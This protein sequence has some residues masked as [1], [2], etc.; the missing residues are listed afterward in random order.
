MLLNE[1]NVY[2]VGVTR[3]KK[4]D[5]PN[6]EQQYETMSLSERSSRFPT[7]HMRLN[8]ETGALLPF[9]GIEVKINN[10][11][12]SLIPIQRKC[13]DPHAFIRVKNVFFQNG[14]QPPPIF[15]LAISND[16]A[17]QPLACRTFCSSPNVS[18]FSIGRPLRSLETMAA[19][20]CTTPLRHRSFDPVD[21]LIA[22]VANFII[23][24]FSCL[25]A[26]RETMH[27]ELHKEENEVTHNSYHVRKS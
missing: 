3:R 27:F 26:A 13:Q 24:T 8:G 14:S 12:S 6:S 11:I 25:Y 7:R 20:A 17:A 1:K 18:T 19:K 4:W 5:T 23:V 10:K 15:P 21:A 16:T 22:G 9:L 2:K